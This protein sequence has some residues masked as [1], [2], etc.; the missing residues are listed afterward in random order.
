MEREKLISL[1][2]NFSVIY[3]EETFKIRCAKTQRYRRKYQ[4]QP[5]I[6]L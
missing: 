3:K 5:R 6:D 1:F 4:T 2:T